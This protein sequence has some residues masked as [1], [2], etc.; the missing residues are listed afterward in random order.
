MGES[1]TPPPACFKACLDGLAHR[2]EHLAET[3]ASERK[4]AL[5]RSTPTKLYGIALVATES[6]T[7]SGS[8]EAA[9]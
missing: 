8:A 5:P 6:L 3:S 1:L 7:N 4:M 2:V 9:A